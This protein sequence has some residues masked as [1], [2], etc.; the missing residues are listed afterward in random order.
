MRAESD[1]AAAFTYPRRSSNPRLTVRAISATVRS[2]ASTPLPRAPSTFSSRTETTSGTVGPSQARS[3][4]ASTEVSP[5][6]VGGT[7]PRTGNSASA[8]TIPRRRCAR[9]PRVL[10]E[11]VRSMLER[12]TV[13][14]RPAREPSACTSR[15]RA[16]RG[17][18]SISMPRL[19]DCTPG[20]LLAVRWG[21]SADATAKVQLCDDGG[22]DASNPRPI[23]SA[24]RRP[25]TKHR[26]TSL[27]GLAADL[28]GAGRVD[29]FLAL[30]RG[31]GER[32]VQAAGALLDQPEA[33]RAAPPCTAART[34][35]APASASAAPEAA[36]PPRPTSPP[37]PCSTPTTSD[38]SRRR[39]DTPAALG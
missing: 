26:V 38:T 7:E 34:S 14:H 30:H 3:F 36:A 11:A 32:H 8:A 12:S 17:N 22:S 35:P 23:P 5:Q 13:S 15:S 18:T 21:A 24:S 2:P 31:S 27:D 20:S 19:N 29:Q 28:D 9:S 16:V 10:V 37:S 33:L 39:A 4:L 1:Q 6:S 25:R